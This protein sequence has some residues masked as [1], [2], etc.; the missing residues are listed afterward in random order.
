MNK[1]IKKMW[2]EMQE[3]WERRILETVEMN[4]VSDEQ[5]YICHHVRLFKNM[6]GILLELNDE[7]EY[8]EVKE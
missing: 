8:T 6:F 3:E 2:E 4:G 5:V 7:S 1:R